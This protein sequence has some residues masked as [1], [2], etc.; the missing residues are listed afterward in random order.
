[1]QLGIVF[2]SFARSALGAPREEDRS[3]AGEVNLMI[4]DEIDPPMSTR[5][6]NLHS[7]SASNPLKSL[8]TRV[9]SKFEGGDYRAAVR[10]LAS[11]PLP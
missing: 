11:K 8:A 5:P 4:R 7:R 1:M 10:L 9:S 2:L 6:G 3:L